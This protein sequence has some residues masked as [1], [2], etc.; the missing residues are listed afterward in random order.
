[1]VQQFE[2]LLLLLFILI[3]PGSELKKFLLARQKSRLIF[4]F[5][6]EIFGIVKIVEQPVMHDMIF[7]K[8]IVFIL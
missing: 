5:T 2:P 6:D 8:A 7:I 3:I 1:M 4:L